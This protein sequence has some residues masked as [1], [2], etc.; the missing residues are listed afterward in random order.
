MEMPDLTEKTLMPIE[1]RSG[2][3]RGEVPIHSGGIMKKL[4]L[5]QCL[6]RAYQYGVKNGG[7]ALHAAVPRVR[8][9]PMVLEKLREIVE[10][11]VDE[12]N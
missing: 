9:L 11:V 12:H 8:N 4:T 3:F 1:K 6:E 2:N 5:E 7:A 10:G